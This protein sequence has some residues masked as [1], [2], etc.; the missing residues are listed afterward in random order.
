VDVIKQLEEFPT[1]LTV[2][3]LAKLLAVAPTTIY[4]WISK[5]G[6]PVVRL[7]AAIRFNP[8]RIAEWLKKRGG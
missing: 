8:A 2:P 5:R 4:T 7:G 1:Y 3:Q 6:I